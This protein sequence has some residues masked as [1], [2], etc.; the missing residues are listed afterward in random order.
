M[1]YTLCF[2]MV[3]C[4]LSASFKRNIYRCFLLVVV[5]MAGSVFTVLGKTV[6]LP[7]ARITVCDGFDSLT[8]ARYCNCL[9]A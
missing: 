8:S 9:Q 1:D 6:V 7:E 4:I 2:V 5:I 3:L